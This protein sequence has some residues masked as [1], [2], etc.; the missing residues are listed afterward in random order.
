MALHYWYQ[1]LKLHIQFDPSV[2][3][4]KYLKHV[5]IKIKHVLCTKILIKTVFICKRNYCCILD[6]FLFIELTKLFF[7]CLRAFINLLFPLPGILFSR[8]LNQ[9]SQHV[10]LAQKSPLQKG[11]ACP[12]YKSRN[13]SLITLPML[14]PSWN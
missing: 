10:G 1:N 8:A 5:N 11:F 7:F 14:L 13:S 4:Q 6:L 9:F 12:S 3:L 2:P